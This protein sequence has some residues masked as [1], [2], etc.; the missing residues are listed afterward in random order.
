MLVLAKVGGQ[1]ASAHGD[2][3]CRHRLADHFSGMLYAGAILVAA[4]HEALQW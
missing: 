3:N 4:T 1:D 2:Q